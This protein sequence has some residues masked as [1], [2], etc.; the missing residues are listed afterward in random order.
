M[1]A[2]AETLKAISQIYTDRVQQMTVK[3]HGICEKRVVAYSSTEIHSRGI[4]L[5]V[6]GARAILQISDL[7]S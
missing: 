6:A 1:H 4:S 3:G 7:T 5:V 2:R